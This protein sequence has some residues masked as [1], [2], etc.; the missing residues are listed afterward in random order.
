MNT[1]EQFRTPISNTLKNIRERR[2]L[3]Q[4]RLAEYLQVSQG[5]LN[6]WESG[7][8]GIPA[9]KLMLF[10]QMTRTPPNDF[11]KIMISYMDTEEVVEK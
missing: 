5:A 9:E 6:H 7:K 4:L 2:G 11:F 10:L 8:T 1:Y 3:T